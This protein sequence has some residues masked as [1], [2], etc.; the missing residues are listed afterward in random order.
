M[1]VGLGEGENYIA[2][3]MPA[4]LPYT[5]RMIFLE[6]GDVA[7]VTRDSVSV[8]R[9]S[10]APAV[11]PPRCPQTVNL[12]PVSAAKAAD[13]HFML[14]EISEQARSVAESPLPGGSILRER[15]RLS[16]GHAPLTAQHA[17]AIPSAI[18][19][20]RL[21]HRLARRSGGQV[22]ARRQMAG[23]P[24]RG[25]L[26]QRV[27][28]SLAAGRQAHAA[29]RRHAVGRDSGH[30]DSDGAGPR[31]MGARVLA[32]LVNVVGSQAGRPS[33]DDV[34]YMHTG[35]DIG[36]AASKTFTL[37][38]IICLY[39]LALAL[40]RLRGTPLPERDT[41]PAPRS[42]DSCRTWWGARWVYLC[43]IPTRSSP[44]V[45]IPSADFLFL[46]RGITYPIALEGALKLKEIS[47]IH[48]EGYPAGEMKHG[49]I[50]LIDEDMPVVAV[51]PQDESYEKM[52]SNIEQV[53]AR[54]GMV[55]AV[56]TEG[57][58]VIA[59]KAEHL[60]CVPQRGPHCCAR[61][62]CHPA[63]AARLPRGGPT[64]DRRR[65]AAESG[66]ERDGG[67]ERKTRFQPETWSLFVFY[68]EQTRLHTLRTKQLKA[69]LHPMFLQ[70]LRHAASPLGGP[71][72]GGPKR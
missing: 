24:V 14:Q 41:R 23:I 67:V 69:D 33:A 8:A 65:P 64:R 50:A 44:R 15:Q 9:V 35:L 7:T 2:S 61:P 52:I 56:G 54:G 3:D 60:L 21:R 39:M 42:G 1:T 13:K 53:N 38:Q 32:A 6:S 62:D 68:R 20:A 55:I 18:L 57:D 30:A 43:S 51:A 36:V 26:C 29:C 34:I 47:Y 63:A 5:R 22:H 59:T 66:E 19:I 17:Q 16:G 46:G 70:T 48:A 12:D 27:P 49:P 72:G 31:Q 40:G 25:R 45:I 58:N 37:S 10:T 11:H 71:G 28:L 4:I